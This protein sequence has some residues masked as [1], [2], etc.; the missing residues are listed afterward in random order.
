MKK[1]VSIMLALVAAA[2]SVG[3]VAAVAVPIL[4]RDV[5]AAPSSSTPSVIPK[6]TD[7]S[8]ASIANG[9]D[10]AGQ[11]TVGSGSTAGYQVS[12]DGGTSLVGSTSQVSGS[13]TV[14]GQ[15][16]TGASVTV[17]TASLS[18]GNATI[19]GYLRH[20]ALQTDTYP[21]ATFRLDQSIDAPLSA[22]SGQIQS[23]TGTG[24]L[25]LHGVTREV[26]ATL[27]TTFGVDGARLTGSIP[28]NFGDYGVTG[29][30]FGFAVTQDAA[31]ITFSLN[32]VKQ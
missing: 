17:Q 16:L 19:D 18:C 21:T 9:M 22:V 20:T 2:L 27:Q 13:I 11:W 3:L 28:I 31:V 5:T 26:T 4:Y 12:G 7:G 25:T 10:L 6:V 29:P 32:A 8:A 15:T 14:V 1:P 24:E 23:L 30:D